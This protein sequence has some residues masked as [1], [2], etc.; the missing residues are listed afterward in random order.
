LQV[1]RVLCVEDEADVRELVLELLRSWGHDALG[2]G[3]GAEL[4]AHLGDP[5]LELVLCDVNVPDASG[6]EHLRMIVR[7]RPDVAT[8]MVTGVDD[9]AL[10][11]CALELG[12]YGYVVKPFEPTELRINVS[13]ALRR[14]H[15]EL[16]SLGAQATLEASVSKRTRELE[17]TIERL[18]NAR[19]ELR[20]TTDEMI[21]RL[22]LALESRDWRTGA[23]T[24]RVSR[25][26]GTIASRLGLSDAECER[27]RIASPLHDVGKIG[28]PDAI[29]LKPGPLSPPERTIIEGHTEAGYKILSGSGS[30]LL[31]FAANIALS[32]HEHVNG[33]GYPSGLRGEE[34]PLAG[35]IVAVADVYDAVTSDRPY[36]PKMSE[37]EALKIITRGSGTQFDAKV[38]KAFLASPH[39]GGRR[40]GTPRVPARRAGK[41]AA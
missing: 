18:E 19:A 13:N 27:I 5:A 29:L 21:F 7:E 39:D 3:T 36:R 15:L 41:I 22:S 8:F 20:L 14:R 34:I 16:E 31:E 12:A 24:I 25:I 40:G 30:E 2:A 38:V 37:A 32:H 33:M 28:I 17:E 26:A 9:P 6:I 11:Q 4:R 23:H 35:R 1:G 10:A